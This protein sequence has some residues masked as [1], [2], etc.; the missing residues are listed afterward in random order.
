[1]FYIYS[2]VVLYP[3]FVNFVDIFEG[4]QPQSGQAYAN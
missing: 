2:I 4:R 3:N 1:M